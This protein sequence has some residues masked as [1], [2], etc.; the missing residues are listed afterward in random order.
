MGEVAGKEDGPREA[1]CCC[2]CCSA[3]IVCRRSGCCRRSYAEGGWY[4]WRRSVDCSPLCGRTGNVLVEAEYDR[5]WP[6]GVN[7][8][9]GGIYDLV[10]VYLCGLE[11]PCGGD[12]PW[13]P[14]VV[15]LVYPTG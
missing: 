14:L 9:G 6:V 15:R 10:S 1:G 3:D 5:E 13:P 8:G 7:C 2:C 4:S 11:G 12:V